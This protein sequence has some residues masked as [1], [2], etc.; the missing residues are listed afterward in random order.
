MNFQKKHWFD[1][2]ITLRF[3]KWLSKQ[4]E[5]N[6]VIGLVWDQAPGRKQHLVFDYLQHQA[7]AGRLFSAFIPAG[8]TSIL[9]VCDLVMNSPLKCYLKKCFYAWKQEEV[10]RLKAVG[11]VGYIEIRV[12]RDR[13]TSWCYDFMTEFN[14][15]EGVTADILLP[16]FT[17]VG[18]N[19]FAHDA[20]KFKDWLD[21]LNKNALYKSLLCPHTA[22][23]LS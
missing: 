10:A 20:N 18:Q 19:A 22:A 1:A 6:L 14:R 17:K 5:P 15:T 7:A 23:D 11:Q 4:F 9:Q 16:C 12:N 21:S 2:V 8:L 13:L 3:L